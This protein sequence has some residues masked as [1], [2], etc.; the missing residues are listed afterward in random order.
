MSLKKLIRN[1]STEI[2][3]RRFL[4]TNGYYGDSAK[5]QEV[6]LVAIARPGWIQVFRFQVN[7]KSSDDDQWRELYGIV[8]DDQRDSADVAIFESPEER[9]EGLKVSNAGLISND[10]EREEHPLKTMLM[11][12]FG[13]VLLIVLLGVVSTMMKT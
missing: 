8:R 1:K 3:I 2:D 13:V 10:R 4:N 6:E 5:F 12:G 7:A 9:D 11:M